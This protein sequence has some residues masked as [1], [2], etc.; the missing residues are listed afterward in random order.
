[1]KTPT[2]K[3]ILDRVANWWMNRFNPN[4]G[5]YSSYNLGMN[6]YDDET[7]DYISFTI[8]YENLKYDK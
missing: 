3:Q 2:L 7:G 6:V 8:G 4:K 5:S 1:M